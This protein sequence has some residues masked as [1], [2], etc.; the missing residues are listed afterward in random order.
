MTD[1]LSS[2][3]GLQRG[4]LSDQIYDLVKTMIKTSQLAPGEQL[5]ESQLAR[6]LQVSQAPVRDALKRLAHEGL[7]T[8]VRHQ[9]NFVAQ[10]SDEEAQQAKQARV[11]VEA[12]A[13]RLACGRLASEARSSLEKVIDE[14]HGAV[15]AADLP[16]FRELDFAFHR[17]VIEAS[18]NTYLPRMWDIIE[19][20]LRSMHLLG[21]PEFTGDWHQVADWHRSLLDVLDAGDAAAASALFEAHAAGTLL[22]GEPDAKTDAAG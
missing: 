17:A 12:L 14:M 5:V 3:S 15:D 6:R 2:I 9:G 8:H 13:G 4:L 20:S 11:A 21:D 22:D 16:A 10:Y 18:G 19:P 7:V 1:A